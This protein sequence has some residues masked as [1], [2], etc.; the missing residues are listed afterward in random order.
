MTES[1]ANGH[2]R[3]TAQLP[4]LDVV[5]GGRKLRALV[6]TGCTR[7]IVSERIPLRSPCRITQ[8]Q[9]RMMDGSMA[10]SSKSAIVRMTI[11]GQEVVLDCIITK[12]LPQFDMLL[13]LDGI[14]KLG[15]VSVD[16][17]SRVIFPSQKGGG[18]NVAVATCNDKEEIKDVDFSA[19][20]NGHFWTVKWKWNCNGEIPCIENRVSQYKVPAEAA[21]EFDKEVKEW[22]SKGWLSPCS[23]QLEGVLPLMAVIQHNKGK[24]RPVLDFREL[25]RS[26]SS[27]T[28]EAAVCGEKLRRWRKL[29]TNVSIIDLRQAYLQIRVDPS[30]WRFQVVCFK[31]K[32]Y[33]LTRLGFGLNVAPKIMTAI[34]T[35]VLNMDEQVRDGTDSYIDDIIVNEDVI[36]CESVLRHLE[37]FG[38]V[39]KDPEKLGGA[40]I[41][42][43]QV[44]H[45]N[46]RFMWTRGNLIGELPE[47]LK[48]RDLFSLCGKL[49]GHF[50]VANW[51]RVACSYAKRCTDSQKWDEEIDDRTML[52]IKD[53]MKRI[54]ASDPVKGEWQV[55]KEAEG[56]VWCD[57][58]SI[59]I[60]VALEMDGK[61]VEDACWL[62]DQNDAGHINLAELE[63]VIKGISMAIKWEI[64]KMTIC[65]DSVSV[66]SWVSSQITKDKKAR[67]HGLGEMLIRRR[68]WIIQK[69][70]EEHGIALHMRLVKSAENRADSLTRVP[71]K[72][73]SS[74]STVCIAHDEKLRAI[75]SAHAKHH[76]GVE[77]TLFLVKKLH[78]ELG[79]SQKEVESVIKTCARCTCVDP[80]PIRWDHGVLSVESN[81]MRLAC[82]IT[83]YGGRKFLTLIDCGPSRY[84]V[85][86]WIK[87][88]HAE[89]VADAVQD[90]IR[91]HGSPRTILVDNGASFRADAF[92]VMCEKWGVKLEFRCAY[93]PSGN[94]I[95][96][97][98][99]RTVKRMA[100][101][102][103]GD[104]RDMAYWLNSSPKS[105]QGEDSV[106][107]RQIFRVEWRPPTVNEEP[108]EGRD[109]G[110]KF[111]VGET[112]VTKP[113]Q[114]RCTTEW[115]KGTVTGMGGKNQVEVDGVPRHIA[116]VRKCPI[117]Q[118]SNTVEHDVDIEIGIE[119]DTANEEQIGDEN[120][121]LGRNGTRVR[122]PPQRMLDYVDPET[123]DLDVIE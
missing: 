105:G 32:K 109:E 92:R 97:R 67:P 66:W 54:L 37:K 88:E 114:A 84:T 75:V 62:R 44:K 19:W 16:A 81:W 23:E 12:I 99:H 41:L 35:K 28:G 64:S 4:S 30:L 49:V 85:W 121:S 17:N 87:T 83:H 98:V 42:G 120:E 61:I 43:L 26:I 45:E 74:V 117:R 51:L 90:V 47:R 93:R 9:I 112:V 29:G 50:P 69:M 107:M 122:R 3:F 86:K 94:G 77:R 2:P 18:E 34:V 13:G 102:S 38:L 82:D 55:P 65:T 40:R 22:I 8:E 101:R 71:Q 5:V 1:C 116:D 108:E 73:L 70:C 78:P 33:W 36:P 11:E 89:E 115:M 57:A 20:F 68:L 48:K 6:D 27:H 31:G 100:A 25:N 39:A 111:A 110:N 119:P 56:T 96:E 95:V 15:G 52:L 59:A 14:A 91:S 58:S 113:P 53:I 118:S 79:V 72:W 10:S 60:G 104:V 24:V 46:E 76:L 80:S 63:A 103:Q 7:S 106:P 123:L 21:E